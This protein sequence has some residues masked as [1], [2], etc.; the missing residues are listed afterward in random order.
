MAVSSVV[1]SS[2][3]S[4]LSCARAQVLL[5]QPDVANKTA[6]SPGAMGSASSSSSL[7]SVA[8]IVA[9]RCH[10]R[11]CPLP[12]VRVVVVVV[13]VAVC[14]RC[15]SVNIGQSA[16]VGSGVVSCCGGWIRVGGT[17]LAALH[18][19]LLRPSQA[20]LVHPHASLVCR[21]S[22]A[23][24]VVMFVVVGPGCWTSPTTGQAYLWRVGSVFGR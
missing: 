9:V 5:R 20:S 8:V 24:A 17:Y 19:P 6:R 3:S 16:N 13:C 22:V 21:S 14:R 7:P 11:R 15:H 10:H 12:S 1:R 23:V 18:S 4:L 2:P